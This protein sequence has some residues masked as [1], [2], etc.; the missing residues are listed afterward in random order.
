M[1]KEDFIERLVQK[2]LEAWQK[3]E[4]GN[5]VDLTACLGRTDRQTGEPVEPWV[6]V[7]ERG[8]H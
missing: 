4:R 1:T 2:G 6:E 3:A 8:W 7:R 5:L